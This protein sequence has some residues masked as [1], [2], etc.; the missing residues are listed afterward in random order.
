MYPEAKSCGLRLCVQINFRQGRMAETQYRR[1][2]N[3][4]SRAHSDVQCASPATHGDFCGKH[5]KKPI[6]FFDRRGNDQRNIFTRSDASAAQAIQ[7]W[8]RRK[9]AWRRI[10]TQGPAIHERSICENETE[11]YS[12]EPVK[13]IPQVFFFSYADPNRHVWGFDIRSLLQILSQGKAL[14]NPY[15]RDEFPTK[16]TA[17]F[18]RRVEWLRKRKFALLYGLEEAITPEQEWNHRVLDIFMKIEALGYLLS[19]SW[20]EDLTMADQKK[21]YRTVYQLWYWRL[22]L[23]PAQRD[24]ICPGHQTN[25]NRLFRQNPDEAERNH[26]DVKWWKKQN[27]NLITSLI[28]RGTSKAN[29]GLGALYTVMGLVTVCDQAAEAYPWIAESLGIEVE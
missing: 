12:L 19:T 6:R 8:W 28:S 5:C 17:K 10:Y 29:K 3:I 16:I 9:A 15:T 25:N 21:F 4:K 2:A 27:L 1:C 20:F 24:E 22:G 26:K 18:R 11:V 7:R 14:Q 13:Q 23:T